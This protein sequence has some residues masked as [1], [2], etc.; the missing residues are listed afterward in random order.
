ML[1]YVNTPNSDVASCINELNYNYYEIMLNTKLNH[2]TK[3]KLI[4]TKIIL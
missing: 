2:S 4:A 3:N 1:Y